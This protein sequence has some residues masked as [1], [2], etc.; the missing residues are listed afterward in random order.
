L[1]YYILR[2]DIFTGIVREIKVDTV[3]SLTLLTPR[4]GYIVEESSYRYRPKDSVFLKKKKYKEGYRVL[5]GQGEG[6]GLDIRV[7]GGLR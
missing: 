7:M 1:I 6:S 5:R 4:T 2:G 3:A